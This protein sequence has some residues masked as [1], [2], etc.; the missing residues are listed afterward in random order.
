MNMPVF[1]KIA[2]IVLAGVLAMTSLQCKRERP[3]FE[4][5]DVPLSLV[6]TSKTKFK[7]NG[8]YVAI[9][10]ANL[11]QRAISANELVEVQKLFDAVG[12]DEVAREVL[13]SNFLNEPDVIIPTDSTMNANIDA[14]IFETYKRFLIREPSEAELA[15]FRY[16][17]EANPYI[18]PELVYFS[19]A[20][21]DEYLYY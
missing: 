4:V 12:D 7:T 10:H 20:L 2:R 9:L 18:T 16:N 6:Q 21:C 8:Q 5:N 19:F 13:V 17:I 3:I 15:Y 1:N 11:F 14:F